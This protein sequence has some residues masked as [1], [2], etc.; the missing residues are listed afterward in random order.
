[1]TGIHADLIAA[2]GEAALARW[3]AGGVGVERRRGHYQ[4]G[5][6]VT[7]ALELSAA[8][9]ARRVAAGWQLVALEDQAH[10]DEVA[11]A[12]KPAAEAGR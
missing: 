2:V 8:D 5:D 6:L 7:G 4:R 10:A 1:M 11:R 12:L 3:F 9:H